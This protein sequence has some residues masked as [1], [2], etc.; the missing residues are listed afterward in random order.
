MYLSIHPSCVSVPLL[1]Y[2]FYPS[3]CVCVFFHC[4]V[5][6]GMPISL[7]VCLPVHT[8]VWG[9]CV[10]YVRQACIIWVMVTS[11]GR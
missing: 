11:P 5:L 1:V 8:R 7:Y 6:P 2:P 10:L 4:S 9:V 3:L